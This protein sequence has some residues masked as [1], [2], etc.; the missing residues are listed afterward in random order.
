MLALAI[1]VLFLVSCAPLPPS[2]IEIAGIIPLTGS[3]AVMGQS[4][5]NGML[6]AAEEINS[7]GGVKGKQLLFIYEDSKADPKEGVTVYKQ[8]TAI[9]NPLVTVVAFSGVASALLP[10]IDSDKM[11]MLMTLVSG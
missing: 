1:L 4:L 2:T 3:G 5:Q 8:I 11:P 6:L 10:L 7:A 9:H